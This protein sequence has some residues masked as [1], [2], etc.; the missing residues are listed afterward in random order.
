MEPSGAVRYRRGII[1]AV[2]PDAVAEQLGQLRRVAS[3]F[4]IQAV[5]GHLEQTAREALAVARTDEEAE[6]ARQLL[7][8]ARHAGLG[9]T[10]RR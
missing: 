6:L 7:A 9:Y 10:V 5:A 3:A 2:T 1:R 8:A 4:G